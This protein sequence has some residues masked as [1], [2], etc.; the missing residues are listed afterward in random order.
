MNV[1]IDES[2]RNGAVAQIKNARAAGR[3]LLALD[4]EV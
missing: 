2:G 4:L 3:V 1:S